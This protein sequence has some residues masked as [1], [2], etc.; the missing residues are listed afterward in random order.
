MFQ[1]NDVSDIYVGK[2]TRGYSITYKVT[3]NDGNC[4]EGLTL[5]EVADHC[6]S[7]LTSLK[8]TMYGTKKGTP[9]KYKLWTIER[10]S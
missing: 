10:E 1:V 9:I 2:N 7:P 4:V 8:V 6:M 3:D 5:R